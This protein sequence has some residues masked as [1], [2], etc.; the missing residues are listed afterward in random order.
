LIEH[1]ATISYGQTLGLFLENHAPSLQREDT[2]LRIVLGQGVD[3]YEAMVDSKPDTYASPSRVEKR[4]DWPKLLEEITAHRAR[5]TVFACHGKYDEKDLDGSQLELSSDHDGRV[6]FSR[7]FKDLDLRGCR[8]VIMGACESG[9]AHAEI[10]AE[11][12]GLPSA[13]LS[14]GV[15]YV[16]GALWTILQIATAVLMERFLGLIKDGTMNV[17][18]ALCCAQRELML[19]TGDEV[20]A[21]VRAK[22]GTGPE[23]EDLFDELAASHSPFAHPY[24]WAGLEAVGDI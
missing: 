14:S 20:S 18:S 16:I 11:Y 9:L 22:M 8:S 6:L 23:L 4:T 21:W 2:P 15:R 19:K 10:S 24:S 12:L 17:C 7:V 3:W 1:C 13:M 5:D